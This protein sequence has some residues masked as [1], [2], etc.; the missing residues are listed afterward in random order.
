MFDVITL[1]DA[2][3]DLFIK[4]SDVTLA[5]PVARIRE[6]TCSEPVL[7]LP[8]GAKIPISEIHFDIGGSAANVAVGLVRLGCQA[9]LIS[10]VGKDDKGREI[11]DKLNKQ[12]VEISRVRQIKEIK[13]SFSLIISY[14]GERTILV[15]RGLEDYSKIQLPKTL[16]S[17]WLYVGPLGEGFQKL[18]DEIVSLVS[19]KN[20]N[21]ALNPG[22]IQ[23][24]SKSELRRILRITKVLFVNKEEAEEMVEIRRPALIK[25]LL[26]DLKSYGAEMVVITDGPEGAYFF[27]GKEFLHIGTY[28]AKKHEV[29]GAGD[30]FSSGFLGALILREDT[31]EAL[32]WGVINSA[33]VIEKVGAQNGLLNI[34]QIER[35]LKK[36][37]FPQKL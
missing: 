7:C 37:P 30:A 22:N 31:K 24:E 36:A 2:V 14:Q 6:K 17:Q 16:K 11:L 35:R 8:Y 23:I 29:T 9:G 10:A 19:T 34:S 13:T 26:Y 27:D 28:Q 1:G 33:S 4:P 5:C 18:Y 21:L 32:R 12:G 25:D 20:I 15:Y 3:S